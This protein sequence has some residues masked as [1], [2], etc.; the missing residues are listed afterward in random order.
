MKLINSK[1]EA[2]YYNTVMKKGEYRFVVKAASGQMLLGRDKEPV[3]SRTF[4]KE[5]T[6]LKYMARHGY[7]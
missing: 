6:A 5:A 3:K 4:A 2:V 7:N 1:G